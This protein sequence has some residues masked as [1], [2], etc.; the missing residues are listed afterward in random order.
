MAK[1]TVKLAELEGIQT[2]IKLLHEVMIKYNE[3]VMYYT[4]EHGKK[5]VMKIMLM[6]DQCGSTKYIIG[7][8]DGITCC[9]WCNKMPFVK[10]LAFC[11]K[12][13]LKRVK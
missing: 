7:S 9:V 1:I 10:K 13:Q 6:C 8:E 4:K 12:S 5:R 3:K 11:I 2:G